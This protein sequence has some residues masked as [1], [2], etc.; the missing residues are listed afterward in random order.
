MQAVQ[1]TQCKEQNSTSHPT[2]T[3]KNVA[4]GINPRHTSAPVCQTTVYDHSCKGDDPLILTI[5]VSTQVV[6]TT[7][8]YRDS[9][10]STHV[11]NGVQDV[12]LHPNRCVQIKRLHHCSP[13]KDHIL[14]A[15]THTPQQLGHHVKDLVGRRCGVFKRVLKC[16]LVGAVREVCAFLYP[17]NHRARDQAVQEEL[18][19]VS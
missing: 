1:K 2:S 6:S 16:L 17:L 13:Y 12:L 15:R 18:V 5:S 4:N 7:C 8:C 3:Q 10:T 9:H 19:L 11:C 14:Q